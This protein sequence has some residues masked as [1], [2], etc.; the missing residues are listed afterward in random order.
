MVCRLRQQ[1]L[2]FTT[3]GAARQSAVWRVPRTWSD[4]LSLTLVA[5]KT[6]SECRTLSDRPTG[7]RPNITAKARPAPSL[8]WGKPRAIH[9]PNLAEPST[10]TGSLRHTLLIPRGLREMLEDEIRVRPASLSL[11]FTFASFYFVRCL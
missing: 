6:R 10:R 8:Q 5:D 11:L 1:T 9:N 4:R 7:S 2:P 3:I